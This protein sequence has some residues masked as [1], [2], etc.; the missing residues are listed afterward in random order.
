MTSVLRASSK[1]EVMICMPFTMM[2]VAENTMADAMT[3]R[4]I[5]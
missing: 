5:R 1:R 2:N 3:I 4:G